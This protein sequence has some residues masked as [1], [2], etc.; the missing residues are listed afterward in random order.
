[1]TVAKEYKVRPS[2]HNHLQETVRVFLARAFFE[3]HGI[4]TGEICNL[5]TSEGFVGEVVAW[6]STEKITTDVVQM[7]T[8][9]Q[10]AYS[11]S[12]ET[13]VYISP[14]NNTIAPA[15]D[16]TL[17]EITSNGSDISLDI[18]DK[19]ERARWTG[20]LE[21]ILRSTHLL[22]T[23]LTIENVLSKGRKKSFQ[24]ESINF[25]NTARLFRFQADTEVLI[26]NSTYENQ[27]IQ[28]PCISGDGLG[29]LSKQIERINNA[30]CTRNLLT[31]S[32]ESY[33]GPSC[34]SHVLIHGLHGT[35][36]TLVLSKVSEAS[37][38]E[39]FRIDNKSTEADIVRIFTN[40]L[41]CQPSVVI[42]DDLDKIAPQ[43]NDAHSKTGETLRQ[44]L[45]RLYNSPTFVIA[46]THRLSDID[47]R[48]RRGLLFCIEIELPVPDS[49]ARAE[50][51]K[52]LTGIPRDVDDQ[53]IKDVAARTHG[54]VGGDLQILLELTREAMYAQ[55]GFRYESILFERPAMTAH[56]KD[57][58]AN[59]GDFLK[60]SL[61]SVRPTAMREIFVETPN[62]LWEDI[63]GLE[64]VK[65]KLRKSIVLPMKVSRASIR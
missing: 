53:T 3:L 62:V 42:I 61:L 56:I 48:L 55:G 57:I 7:S 23:G 52:V 22:T 29:G 13:R 15:N 64:D 39:V 34:G 54:F 31:Q 35:G 44:Q 43:A 25:S 12:L 47:R 24:I 28:P 33:P 49:Q 58:F 16:V 37:W 30:I 65:A 41:K 19:V 6:A 32:L 27:Y 1:M 45:G 40:A 18:E 11:L 46:A 9:L 26:A 10:K 14:S 50:I 38:R 20:Q 21:S 8:S 17:R 2:P 59:N 51:L 63:G 5:R 4:K 36:K 60:Q